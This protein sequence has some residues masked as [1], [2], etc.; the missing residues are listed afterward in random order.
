MAQTCGKPI[1]LPQFGQKHEREV[2]MKRWFL[3]FL[4]FALPV[5]A[6]GACVCVTGIIYRHGNGGAICQCRRYETPDCI[7]G[8]CRF[9]TECSEY[10]PPGQT[11]REYCP[12][13]RPYRSLSAGKGQS[14]PGVAR[15]EAQVAE[16]GDRQTGPIQPEGLPVAEDFDP[17]KEDRVGS[18][19]TATP[20]GF[21]LLKTKD[22]IATNIDSDS[23]API[24]KDIEVKI[25]RVQFPFNDGPRFIAY[26]CTRE[27]APVKTIEA[28]SITNVRFNSKDGDRILMLKIAERDLP[29]VFGRKVYLLR[30]PN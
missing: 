30:G 15:E 24:R 9:P 12:G 6:M 29:E 3:L 11:A 18:E 22:K 19:T 23:T 1:P 16:K 4:L 14:I 28:R 10:R 20:I 21:F 13:C 2:A 5:E 25:F 26:E 17:V 7:K 8:Q 27:S